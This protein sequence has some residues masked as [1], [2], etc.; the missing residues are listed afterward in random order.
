M[1]ILKRVATGYLLTMRLL[2]QLLVFGVLFSLTSFR[3]AAFAEE[4]L[5][6]Q[7]EH[8]YSAGD[9]EK[10]RL[11]L[12]QEVLAH[13]RSAIAHY[14][15]AN[16][17]L[18]SGQTTEAI[19]EYQMCISIDPQGA[20]GRYSRLALKSLVSTP[21]NQQSITLAPAPTGEQSSMRASVQKVSNQTNERELQGL[22]ECNARIRDVRSEADRKI[23][24]LE[25][26]KAQ[27][28]LDNGPVVYRRG[29]L[30]GL[31]TTYNPAAANQEIRQDYDAQI[32]RV[33]QEADKRIDEV[34]LEY[35]K[36]AAALE[37]SALTVDKTYLNS[38]NARN[39]TLIPSGT[40]IYTRNYQTADEASGQPVPMLAAPPK[41]LPKQPNR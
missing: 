13:P 27:R 1:S 11:C 20:S 3:N 36:R 8:Y 38:Q 32:T 22:S 16:A 37:D 15:L 17:L 4:E 12:K 40:D 33:R 34:T 39:V 19:K 7:G 31:I 2:T 18:K 14:Y 35:K 41:A 30:G 10:A 9:I 26:E 23:N 5:L 25:T 29:R 21:T 28:I 24:E 6:T